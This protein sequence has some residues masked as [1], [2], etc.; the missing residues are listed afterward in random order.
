MLLEEIS[1]TNECDSK[2]TVSTLLNN[3]FLIHW[4]APPPHPTAAYQKAFGEMET[5]NYG[6][7]ILPQYSVVISEL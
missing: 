3:S 7:Y 1:Q 4:L 5:N 6:M 2:F